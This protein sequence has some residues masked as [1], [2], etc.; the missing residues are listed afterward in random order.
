MPTYDYECSR[1]HQFEAT[2]RIT[3]PPL[4]RCQ[5]CRGKVRRLISGGTFILKGSGWY[6]DGYSSAATTGGKDA[7][8]SEAGS[9]IDKSSNTSPKNEG[10]SA[11]TKDS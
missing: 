3:D 6:K 9:S 7:S 5:V 8:K 10:K 2:Q 1:G 4:D 11:T